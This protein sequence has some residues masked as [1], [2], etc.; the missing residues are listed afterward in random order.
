MRPSRTGFTRRAALAGGVA[1]L[2][3]A[4]LPA[5]LHAAALVPT[6]AQSEGPFYPVELPPETDWDLLRMAGAARPA[7]GAVTYVEGAILDRSGRPVPQAR[8]EIWQCDAH[9]RYHHPGDGHGPL[10]EGFQG[11]GRVV[12]GA[13][14]AY[15]FRTIR[16]VA[17]PGRTPH[18]HFAVLAPGTRRFITQMYVEGEP[19]NARD[20]LLNSV[21]DEVARRRLVVPLR[22]SGEEPGAL[23]GRFEIVLPV[24]L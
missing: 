22:P 6:P 19:G 10:D 18:I 12:T 20:F 16:P 17:Y 7:L 1:G 8:V 4:A 21:R 14:G 13:D 11:F 3:W 15:R 9:G 5:A 24:A 23:Q 2:A